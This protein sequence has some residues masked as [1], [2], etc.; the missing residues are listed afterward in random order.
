M[1][2]DKQKNILLIVLLV[3]IVS[4]TIAY[5]TL[6]QR[7]DIKSSAVV[8]SKSSSWDVHFRTV[9]CTATGDAEVTTP[10]SPTASNTTEL[11]GLVATFKAP[12]DTVTC[13]FYVEN[14][15]EIDA[16]ITAVQQQD[17]TK[18]ITYE[19]AATDASKKAAD[20]ALVNGK[21]NY[22]MSYVEGSGPAVGDILASGASKQL[23]ITLTFDSNVTE[24]PS[25]DVT[26]T[27][28]ASYIIYGQ[29]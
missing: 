19:S 14:S 1:K 8:Q 15:G 22:S 25:A 13:T 11:S 18:T 2:N 20:E 24:L 10:L 6:S 23:K 16:E 28:F 3:G 17:A 26:I 7:L 12:G 9:S 5:A 27:N 4:M 29:H 21:I